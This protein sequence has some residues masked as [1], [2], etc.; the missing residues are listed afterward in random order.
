MKGFHHSCLLTCLSSRSKE[1]GGVGE[2]GPES[3]PG[4]WGEEER[5]RAV[6]SAPGDNQPMAGLVPQRISSELPDRQPADWF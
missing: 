2:G 1:W 6:V 3:C 4:V 5:L